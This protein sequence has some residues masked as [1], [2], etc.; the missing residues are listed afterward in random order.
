MIG[1]HPARVA[2]PFLGGGSQYPSV[3]GA[4]A[5]I[6]YDRLSYTDSG[7]TT[8]ASA[9]DLIYSVK[10]PSG[11]DALSTG[12]S[13]QQPTAG[14]RPTLRSDGAQ[15]NGTTTTMVAPATITLAGDMTMVVVSSRVTTG[16]LDI[17]IGRETTSTDCIAVWSD[18]NCYVQSSISTPFTDNLTGLQIRWTYRS[19]STLYYKRSGAAIQSATNAGTFTLDRLLRFTG[20]ITNTAARQRQLWIMNSAYAPDSAVGLSII[21]AIQSMY[22][23][24]SGP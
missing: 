20:D 21:S 14:L 13:F 6:D 1:P 17:P 8:R 11:W 23:G 24:I 5:L 16:Q 12:G 22:P 2:I 3:V 7:N 4:L 19:G 9:G 18:G 15:T 10:M